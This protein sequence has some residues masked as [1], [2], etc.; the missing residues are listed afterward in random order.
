MNGETTSYKNQ[1]V[2]YRDRGDSADLH[3]SARHH[4]R[5]RGAEHDRRQ[6]R[7]HGVAGDVD[8]DGVSH[9]ERHRP[10]GDGV[11]FRHVWAQTLSPGVHRHFHAGVVC[12]RCR[13]KSNLP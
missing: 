7:F 5:Q 1:S 2:D 3:R 9:L 8:S 4:G 6:S 12:L 11:V 10:A 13:A